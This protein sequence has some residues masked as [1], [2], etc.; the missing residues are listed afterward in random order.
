MPF[1]NRQSGFLLKR[2]SQKVKKGKPESGH[3]KADRMEEAL[4]KLS[5][6]IID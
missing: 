4:S 1:V 6:K 2:E 3:R 5:N